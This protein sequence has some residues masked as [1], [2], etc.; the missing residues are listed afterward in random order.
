MQ[1]H[2]H[3]RPIHK[4]IASY[5]QSYVCLHII[6]CTYTSYEIFGVDA[7]VVLENALASESAVAY[8]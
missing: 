8:N 3:V 2:A 7:G 1:I 6:T 5:S 4:Q